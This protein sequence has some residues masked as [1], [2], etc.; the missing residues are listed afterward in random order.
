MAT[1]TPSRLT[2]RGLVRPLR[3]D[4]KV[5]YASADGVALILSNVGQVLGTKVGEVRWRRAFGSQ[6]HRLRHRPDHPAFQSLAFF[7]AA[8]ALGQ[9]ERRVRLRSIERVPAGDRVFRMRAHVDV[10]LA[11]GAVLPR[12]VEFSVNG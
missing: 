3:R 9:W 10:V 1:L 6:L 11:D 7:F 12:D 5:D 2:G 8:Q 4:E